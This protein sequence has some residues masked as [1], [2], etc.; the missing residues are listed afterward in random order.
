MNKQMRLLPSK[1]Y[2]CG[3]GTKMPRTRLRVS[4]QDLALKLKLE[5]ADEKIRILNCLLY[6]ADFNTSRTH[7]LRYPFR[8]Y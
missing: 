5:Y 7:P 4:S 1:L 2:L 3:T 8:F 6:D